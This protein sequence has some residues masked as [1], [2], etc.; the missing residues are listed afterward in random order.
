MKP[1]AR[2]IASIQFL[3]ALLVGAVTWI[4]K[5][6]AD[7]KAP[8]SVWQD[9]AAWT[10]DHSSGITFVLAGA[11]AAL[12]LFK[13]WPSSFGYQRSTLEK[14]L[15][16]FAKEQFKGRAKVH[17]LTLYKEVSGR[18]AYWVGRWR[19]FRRHGDQ[20][21]KRAALETIDVRARYLYAYA[22]ASEARNRRST[23]AW[24][25]SDRKDECEGIAGLAWEEGFC[26]APDLPKLKEGSLSSISTLYDLPQTD[27]RTKYAASI[28]VK[29]PALLRAM[30][31]YARHY[32]ATVVLVGGK[33]WGVLVLDSESTMCP[34][35]AN[36]SGGSVGKQF[37]SFAKQLTHVLA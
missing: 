17:R 31:T 33:P 6:E 25:V 19:L 18:Y 9:L 4:A 15:D 12:A 35:S 13:E 2:I 21:R 36:G 7:S 29:N 10:R 14:L 28:N 23:A 30:D 3:L 32:M 24:K 26:V 16:Q 34:F 37:K 11:I 5:P 22:R 1:F 8:H 20:S 27:V